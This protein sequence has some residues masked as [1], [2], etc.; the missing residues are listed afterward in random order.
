MAVGHEPSLA[1]AQSIAAA[2][3]PPH[4]MA[5]TPAAK[6]A[7][8]P[9]ALMNALTST[10][11]GHLTSLRPALLAH[12]LECMGDARTGNPGKAVNTAVGAALG[13]LRDASTRDTLAFLL[14]LHDDP[15]RILRDVAVG[16]YTVAELEAI[17]SGMGYVCFKG[18]PI[19]VPP[20]QFAH[21]IT[22]LCED[23]N[24]GDVVRLQPPYPILLQSWVRANGELAVAVRNGKIDLDV[25][26]R[27]NLVFVAE[28]PQREAVSP[29]LRGEVS[30]ALLESLARNCI[31]VRDAGGSVRPP[32]TAAEFDAVPALQALR[33][34]LTFG[35]K[36][37]QP[38]L[39]L[40]AFLGGIASTPA[41]V[42]PVVPAVRFQETIGWE[43]LLAFRHLRAHI[44][45]EP[46][47]LTSNGLTAAVVADA[48]SAAARV[49]ADPARGCFSL[50]G[51]RLLPK[52]R[53]RHRR[54]AL[55]GP[56]GAPLGIDARCA[57]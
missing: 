7:I 25:D 43:L 40:A 14:A 50:E 51:S 31:G 55:R 24:D 10:A 45:S 38:N 37:R 30:I 11:H 26:T 16:D 46:A 28:N 36:K 27:T 57:A 1:A 48:V 3:F 35:A 6:V 41:G 4:T 5:W 33:D 49:L 44:W 29:S 2:I 22:C 56:K 19:G 47:Q 15:R 23:G 39:S 21:L 17:Q 20:E 32:R 12:T 18:I 9:T 34:M 8:T 52:P 54:W 42:A 53:R 13:E